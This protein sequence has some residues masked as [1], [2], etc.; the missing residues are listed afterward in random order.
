MPS[1]GAGFLDRTAL[2]S[3]VE[4]AAAA[5]VVVAVVVIVV[6]VVAA[7]A[8]VAGERRMVE[9]TAEHRAVEPVL[10]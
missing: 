4:G 2:Y 5:A 9:V 10:C 8:V 3:S 1:S 6:A 7:V